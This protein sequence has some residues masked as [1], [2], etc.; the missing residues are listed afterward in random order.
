MFK[1][2]WPI[3]IVVSNIALS[4]GVIWLV[5]NHNHVENS[6]RTTFGTQYI[7]YII[8]VNMGLAFLLSNFIYEKMH[9]G[10]RLYSGFD[11]SWFFTLSQTITLALIANIMLVN[12][13][14]IVKLLVNQLRRCTDRFG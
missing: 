9:D 12:G 4:Y 7:L 11:H 2:G 3:A 8:L 14:E 1:I 5:K 13:F 10:E 6:L